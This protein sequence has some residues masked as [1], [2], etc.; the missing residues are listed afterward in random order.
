LAH[1]PQ[2]K[3]E[4]RR[5]QS[6]SR[7]ADSARRRAVARRRLAIGAVVVVVLGVGGYL[8]LSG[9]DLGDIVPF[10]P[11]DPEVTFTFETVNVEIRTTGRPG[12]ALGSQANRAADRIE[13]VMNGLY[14]VTFADKRYWGD[15]GDAWGLFDETAAEGAE[16]DVDVLTLGAE[17]NDVYDTI[18]P[19]G[20]TLT[21]IVLTNERSRPI[22]AI[23]EVAFAATTALGDGTATTVASEGTYFLRPTEDGWLIYAYRVDRNEEATSPSPSVEAS[24]S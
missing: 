7:R 15:Y 4:P 5:A 12:A 11:N 18:T 22:S 3:A 20:T 24:P 2:I 10:V 23:A 19:D 17:A 16:A 13:T 8:L 6:S 14:T 9:D 21:I 1:D